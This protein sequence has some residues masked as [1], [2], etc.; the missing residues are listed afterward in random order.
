MGV[1]SQ[2]A[3]EVLKKNLGRP[4][5][6]LIGPGFGTE[7]VTRDFLRGLIGDSSRQRRKGIGFVTSDQLEAVEDAKKASL[8]PFVIDADGL[9]LLAMIENWYKS[10]PAP[11]VLTP[12]PGEMSVLTD[13]SVSDIQS[14][15]L[16][17]AEK[18]AQEWG[19]VV[20]LK[21]ANTVV[22]SP[23]GQTTVIPVASPALAKAGTGDVLAG[24]IVGLRAQG[25]EA[26][27]AAV[28]GCWIHAQAGLRAADVLGS[29]VAVLAGD[30]LEAV[31]I[32][33]SE[34][35]EE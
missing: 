8:P 6:M 7:D 14:D 13:L 15:R 4:T 22:A 2:A 33:M 24:L 5:A 27:P 19:H 10:I 21:G 28:A 31:A 17:T 29:T 3:V 35:C 25:V 34:L 30:V 32:V 18:F 11:A 9:K 12:H 26:Y 23:D 20:V 16:G 1:I